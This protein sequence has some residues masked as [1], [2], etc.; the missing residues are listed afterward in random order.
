M[1]K[2]TSINKEKVF[3]R[4]GELAKRITDLIYEYENDFSLAS[5]VGIL[6]IVKTEIQSAN[7]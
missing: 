4:E 7:N 1:D 3:A 6:E 2:V 5:I